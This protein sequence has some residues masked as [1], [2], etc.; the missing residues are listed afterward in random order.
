MVAELVL[1]RHGATEW[2]VAGKHTSYTDLP[3]LPT[4][5]EQASR[6]AP[7]LVGQQFA[8]VW[9][10]P[11]A[12]ARQTAALAGFS[13][14]VVDPDLAEWN[15][16]IYEGVTTPEIRESNPEWTIWT[17]QTPGGE[18]AAQI[19]ERL[20]RVVERARA[21]DGSSLVFAHGHSLRAL[22]ARWLGLPVS[23]GRL[24]HLETGTISRLGF[25]R[26]QPVI[27]QWNA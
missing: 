4:G 7:R 18:S 12:R 27:L 24:F 3:L 1:V 19:T 8:T 26:E 22:T 6:L 2:S 13:D 9:S 14:A 5:E 25:E 10:S 16:G 15:Y 20:D 21:T 17:G 11:A 23:E